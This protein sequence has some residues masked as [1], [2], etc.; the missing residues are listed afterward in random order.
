MFL[1]IKC[2]IDK[3]R[4][5]EKDT[6]GKKS[7]PVTLLDNIC[8]SVLDAPS[9]GR[10]PRDAVKECRHQAPAGPPRRKR[11]KTGVISL[12]ASQQYPFW[13]AS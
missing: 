4:L 5:K 9:L 1:G 11:E 10:P 7:Q 3:P 13:I 8:I 2:F 12:S 6:L